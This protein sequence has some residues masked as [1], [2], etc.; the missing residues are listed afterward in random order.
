MEDLNIW[1]ILGS[2]YDLTLEISYVDDFIFVVGIFCLL[3]F[4]FS[5]FWDVLHNWGWWRLLCTTGHL[6]E[7]EICV[8][9]YFVLIL[10]FL[11]LFLN[12]YFWEQKPLE[13]EY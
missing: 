5:S 13:L 9:F 4:P 12:W 6:G 2:L 8:V 3:S 7:R 11:I 1:D 10:I